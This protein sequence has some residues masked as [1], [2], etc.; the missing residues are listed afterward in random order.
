MLI[1]ARENRKCNQV[2][3]FKDHQLWR[4]FLETRYVFPNSVI[5]TTTKSISLRIVV[6]E[7]IFI[8]QSKIQTTVSPVLVNVVHN[9]GVHALW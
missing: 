9:K 4:D 6:S 8:L 5:N 2:S 1:N 3:R 7:Q